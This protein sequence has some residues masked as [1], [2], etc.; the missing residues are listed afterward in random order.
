MTPERE[1]EIGEWVNTIVRMDEYEGKMLD[2]CLEEIDSLRSR[3]ADI[4][5]RNRDLEEKVTSEFRRGYEQAIERY[6]ITDARP[7]PEGPEEG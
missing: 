4:E 6:C 1:K 5:G 7:L 3:L 2:D